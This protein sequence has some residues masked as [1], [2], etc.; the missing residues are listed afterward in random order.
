MR[1]TSW[2]SGGGDGS[3]GPLLPVAVGKRVLRVEQVLLRCP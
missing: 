1:L 2:T 3:D